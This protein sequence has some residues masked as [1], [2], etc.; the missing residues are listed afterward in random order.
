M[1]IYI[2]TNKMNGKSYI[3]Q[4]TKKLSK[5][6]YQHQ[7]IKRN[8]PFSNAIRKYGFE[9]FTWEIIEK[10]DNQEELDEM[11]FH[12]IKQ[13]NTLSP[14]GYNLTLGF[15]NTTTGYKYTKSQKEDI[16]K[17]VSGKNN[18]NY[19]NG[20]KIRGDKNP[21]KRP[22]V[23]EKIR[24]SKLGKKRPDFAKICAKH[25]IITNLLTGEKQQ[26][27]NMAEWLRNNPGFNYTGVKNVLKGNWK[28]Y[29]GLY[30]KRV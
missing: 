1:I 2:S 3:G 24:Q 9:N 26:I 27:F 28:Q 4:T 15:G 8:L 20:D 19:G 12:Y 18:P 30:F 16:S 13:Y 21:A 14:N 23:R 29:H 11:E 22:E 5:R 6:I 25:F 7:K 10:C 17:R